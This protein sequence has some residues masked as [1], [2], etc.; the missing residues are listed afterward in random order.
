MGIWHIFFKSSSRVLHLC[1]HLGNQQENSETLIVQRLSYQDNC[2]DV[3]LST[4]KQ[5]NLY[6][7]EQLCNAVGWVKRPFRKV[8]TAIE[9]SFL[10][11]SLLHHDSH[12]DQLIGF[13]RATSDQAFNATIWDVVIHPEFQGK[14]LGKILMSQIIKRLRSYD[15]TNI[16]LFADPQV[17][18][19]YKSLGFIPD[20]DGVKGMFWYPR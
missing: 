2:I 18:L 16:T 3:Y 20:P 8:K 19:F 1:K 17:L 5:V 6:K 10:I 14:G 7:L 15:I 13:A 12:E 4:D 11:I 9:N